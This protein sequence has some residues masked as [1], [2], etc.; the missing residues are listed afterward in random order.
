MS[1]ITTEITEYTPTAQALAEFRQRYEN[2]VFPV[3]TTEGMRKAIEARREIRETRVAL[4]A[5]RKE[6]KEPALRR[7]QLIDAEAKRITAELEALENPIDAQI[8]AEQERKEREKREAAEREQ[9]RRDHVDACMRRVRQFVTV[10]VGRSSAA[11]REQLASLISA[12]QGADT[13]EFTDVERRAY[14]DAAEESAAELRK[15]ADEMEAH[16]AEQ[17]RMAAERAELER[18]QAELRRQQ[19][20]TRARIEEAEKALRDA[21]E[22][23]AK[24]EREKAE[25]EQRAELER[26]QREQEAIR[27]R[28]QAEAAER[29]RIE[30]EARQEAERK[31]AEERAAREA[32]ERAQA[33]ERARAEAAEAAR[34]E[35][36]ER[37][38]FNAMSLLDA[39]KL[40]LA[41][42]A[43]RGA[44]RTDAYKALAAQIQIHQGS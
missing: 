10:S 24:A 8:K 23:Q 30:R 33:E 44:S 37:A 35:A 13:S 14:A 43:S 42:L 36:E 15:M 28:E 16:E 4:E 5:K 32:A 27:A 40:A 2:A 41:E 22:A 3:A 38:R 11:V 21:Q 25:A 19:E 6:I 9:R 7:C 39:A 26:V 17:A 29:E 12:T 1:S 34:L 31:A 20:E 18:Q